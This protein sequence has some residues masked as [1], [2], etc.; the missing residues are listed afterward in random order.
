MT[1]PL[2]RQGQSKATVAK[3]RRF[4]S[5]LSLGMAIAAQ[6]CAGYPYWHADTNAGC[7]VNREIHDEFGQPLKGSPIHA[8]QIAGNKGVPDLRAHFCDMDRRAISQL[9][10]NVGKDERASIFHG[11]NQEFL[12]MFAEKIRRSNDNTKYATGSVLV[13]PNG[14]FYRNRNGHGAPID[15]VMEIA[16]EFPRIDIVLNLNVR[17]YQMM[18]HHQ[19]KGTASYNDLMTPDD[20]MRRMKKKHWLV[21]SIEARGSDRFAVLIG[22]NVQTDEHPRL[23][24]FHAKSRDGELC[25]SEIENSRQGQLVI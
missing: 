21:S 25:L 13:D 11:D 24:L 20:I 5:A 9:V 8:L 3:E 19:R 18:R 12:R 15:A 14:W 22:R 17:T 2:L 6:K 16:E 1:Q 4:A 10:H 7:G 23:G